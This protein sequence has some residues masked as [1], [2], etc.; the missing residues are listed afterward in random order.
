MDKSQI[1][2]LLAHTAQMSDLTAA[3]DVHRDAVR[4]N[5]H[6]TL[7]RLSEIANEKIHAL[8]AAIKKWSTYC[9][10]QY[11][12]LLTVKTNSPLAT[13]KLLRFTFPD[14]TLTEAKKAFDSVKR[15]FPFVVSKAPM[16]DHAREVLKRQFK[17]IGASLVDVDQY[18]K[19]NYPTY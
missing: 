7:Q 9:S 14:L 18:S 10:E 1:S 15:G 4:R 13:V 8:H 6:E 17:T 11:L 12:L 2:Y 19:D 16:S 5:D 3:E